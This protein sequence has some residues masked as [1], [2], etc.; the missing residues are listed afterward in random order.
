MATVK[1]SITLNNVKVNNVAIDNLNLQIDTDYSTEE[2]LAVMQALPQ[3][4][5]E[6]LKVL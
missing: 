6:L 1:V 5:G 3:Y 4:L 2:M